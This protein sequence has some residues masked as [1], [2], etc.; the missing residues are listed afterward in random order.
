MVCDKILWLSSSG[1]EAGGAKAKLGETMKKL[2]IWLMI[3][4]ACQLAFAQSD[5]RSFINAQQHYE[6]GNYIAAKQSLSILDVSETKTLDYALLRGKTHLALGEYTDAYF[7]LS[8]YEKNSLGT[9]DAIS[10]YLLEMIWEASL[11]QEQSPL[12][13]ALGK[14]R[15]Q[16]NTSASEYAPV[17]TPDGKYMYFSSLRRSLHGKE[18]I[19]VS[20]QKNM[21]WDEPMEVDELCTDF[22]E[23]LGSLSADGKT[24]YLFGYYH[25]ENT[26]G[27]IYFSKMTDKGKWSKPSYISEVSSKFHDLQPFVYNDEVMVFTSNRHGNHDNYDLY[28][29]QKSGGIWSE[30]VNLGAAINTPY[31]EQTPFISPDGRYLYFASNGHAGYGGND[32]FVARKIGDAW[33]QWS[34]PVNVGPI[35]NSVKDDRYYTITNDG[36][37]AYLSSNRHGGTGMEDIYYLDLGL[38]Q[39]V[40]DK[41]AAMSGAGSAELSKDQYMISGMVSGDDGR[42]LN[43]DVVWI[44]SQNDDVYMRII[45]T[46][47]QGK[48]KFSLPSKIQDLSYE[49][50]HPGYRKTAA[51]VNLPQGSSDL[52][53]NIVCLQDS[54]RL[55][56][57]Q[58]TINGKVLDENDQPVACTVRWSYVFEG[59]LNEVLVQSGAQGSF[60]LHVP[61]VTKLK[62][63]VDEP[64]YG[65]REEILVLPEGIDS[66][67]TTIRLVSLGNDILVYGKVVGINGNPL[68][69]NLAWSYARGS[70]VVEYRVV[71]NVDG[72][73]R[74]NL[75]RQPKFD[76][77]VAKAN[78]MQVSGILEP[79]AGMH[80]IKQ[81]FRLLRLEEEAVF[82]LENVEF[83]FG[84]ATLTPA[85]LKI[86]EPVLAT[87]QSNSSLEIELSGHTDNIGTRDFNLK[88][89]R[90]RAKAV[91][92]HLIQDGIE[93]TRIKTVGFA[94]DKP[95][96]SNSTPEGRQK[97]R[98]T[99]LKILGIEYSQDQMDDWDREFKEAGSQAR[100][101]K[102]VDA[103]SSYS[104]SQFGI[105]VSLEDEFRSMIQNSLGNT[106][107]AS[108]KV[109]LFINNGKIQAANVNDLMGNL[110]EK[111]VEQIADLMLGWKVQS[112]Q[113]SIY[114]FSVKK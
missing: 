79:P 102:T 3:L 31:D 77:R 62:Y 112:N 75:P 55:D 71:S 39:R 104:T 101:V 84:K 52:F 95:I 27:D 60:K 6:L 74:V 42:A 88:L 13:V 91:G 58:M 30:P 25:K 22:N 85:S 94:F 69:A 50:N 97:N 100:I 29:S 113:R 35:V 10:G 12:S 99:E 105:P 24:A 32:I 26:K 109:D 110:S 23:S 56:C 28:I 82:Q 18:N 114:S 96:A 19:F 86:L 9:Q 92:D 47:A 70:E 90:D 33:T 46:D 17:L 87:M 14:L 41:I 37:Y 61:C 8:E 16:I 1:F 43:A 68:S 44:Y 107:Q 49:V 20:A 72:E 111:L 67:D 76:Y 21:V 80:D 81:D 48:F 106:K 89:S 98:R 53:V 4:L 45:P 11:Y 36:Q 108:L 63:N 51:S 83:E 34:T 57:K 65:P 7:W 54:D 93:S 78:Y 103:Q 5:S 59:E 40:K 38:L 73:Y 15:G 2:S 64:N 66:Y